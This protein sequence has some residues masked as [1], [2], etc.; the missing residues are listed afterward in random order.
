MF[1]FIYLWSD[2]FPQGIMNYRK[3]KK[4]IEWINRMF[5]DDDDGEANTL[6]KQ[7]PL[8]FCRRNALFSIFNVEFRDEK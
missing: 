6:L 1:L 2:L 4:S 3:K 8:E 7:L 5:L